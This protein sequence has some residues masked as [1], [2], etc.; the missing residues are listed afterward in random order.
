MRSLKIVH[1]LDYDWEEDQR[2]PH[3]EALS[4]YCNILCVEPPLTIDILL[5]KP[6]YFCVNLPKIIHQRQINNG[7]FVYKPMMLFSAASS[8]LVPCINRL[9]LVV[10]K[11]FLSSVINKLNMCGGILTIRHPAWSFVI[12]RMN[13]SFLCYEVS[14]EW[15]EEPSAHHKIRRKIDAIEKR[16]LE[17]ADIVFC[18]SKRLTNTKKAINPNTFFVPNAADINF[19]KSSLDHNLLIP[20]ELEKIP[21]P[22]IG[23]I[24]YINP[25]VDVELISFLAESNSGWSIILIGKVDGSRKFL[26]SPAYLKTRKLNNVYYL[27]WK[28]YESLPAYQK[29]FDI[30]MLPYVVSEYTKNVYPNKVYQYLAGGKPVVSTY[31]PELESIENVIFIAKT[32]NEFIVHIENALSQ[33]QTIFI[34]KRLA[35]AHENSIEKNAQLRFSYL[36][37]GVSSKIDSSL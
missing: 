3:I 32:Y 14:D 17:R 2:R 9:N 35:I 25:H 18:S 34:Q 23:L 6:K 20:R 10:I 28:N 24:G 13:Q 26:N 4:K 16:V 37:K 31:L 7:L 33:D 8:L 5:R 27:G 21:K 1:F 29:G 19:F 11:L 36:Q 12:G 22:R 30:C 15:S